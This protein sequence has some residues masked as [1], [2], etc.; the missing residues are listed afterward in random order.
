MSWRVEQEVE[1]D[2]FPS[3]LWRQAKRELGGV[4]G[5]REVEQRKIA[6]RGHGGIEV[7][8]LLRVRDNS[9]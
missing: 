5:A 4:G 3:R 9:F 8:L 1:I 6:R 7:S 2:V